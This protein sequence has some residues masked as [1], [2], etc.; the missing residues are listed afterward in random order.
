M[1]RLLEKAFTRASELPDE[2]QDALAKRLL[3]EIESEKRWDELF[4]RSQ[5]EM[6]QLADKAL[7]EHRQGETQ[8]LDPSDL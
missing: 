7:A 8:R 1:T 5:D 4:A 2:D 6:G 3:A